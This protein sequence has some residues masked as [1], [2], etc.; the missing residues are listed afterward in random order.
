MAGLSK[1]TGVG[2]LA[3]F[4]AM[5]APSG[6]ATP[7]AG[8]ASLYQLHYASGS[9]PFQK[10]ANVFAT[11][12]IPN[13]EQFKG[14]WTG[15]GC[16]HTYPERVDGAR[17]LVT[18]REKSPG[19]LLSRTLVFESYL[20]GAQTFFDTFTASWWE[21]SGAPFSWMNIERST[22]PSI[23][24]GALQQI[25]RT[26]PGAREADLVQR[27]RQI[28]PFLILQTQARPDGVTNTTYSY[29]FQRSI[30]QR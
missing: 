30:I 29:F 11:G 1:L 3:L 28:G 25:V 9:T 5:C 14:I 27:L 4:V 17:L 7:E 22:S 21:L 8:R 19:P 26:R 2:L 20:G 23:V 16:F 24:D 10:L 13:L 6:A 12:T 15:R 18:Y